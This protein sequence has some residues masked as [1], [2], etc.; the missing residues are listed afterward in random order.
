MTDHPFDRLA[1]L[2]SGSRSRRQALAAL[3]ALLMTIMILTTQN[4][5]IKHAEQRAHLD[6]QVN[7]RAE[8]K[9]AKLI[10]LVEELRRDLPDVKNRVDPVADAMTKAVDPEDVMSKLEQTF[11]RPSATDTMLDRSPPRSEPPK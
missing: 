10:Q 9:I 1:R 11:E 2:L 6:L 7:L 4:R 3:G 8:Q 5:Q